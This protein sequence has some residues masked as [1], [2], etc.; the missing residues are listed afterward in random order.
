MKQPTM[1]EMTIILK[2]EIDDLRDKKLSPVRMKAAVFGI[3]QYIK[4]VRTE[5][6]YQ[7]LMGTKKEMAQ[8]DN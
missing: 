6:E 5:I 4:S 2:Q 8:F 1:S 7:K 3:A